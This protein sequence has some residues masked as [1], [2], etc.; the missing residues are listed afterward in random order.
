MDAKMIDSSDQD[1]LI[2]KGGLTLRNRVA[3]ERMRSTLARGG[4]SKWAQFVI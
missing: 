3:D 4:P 2:V 1:G